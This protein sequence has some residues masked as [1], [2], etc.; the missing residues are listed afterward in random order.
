VAKYEI[1][2]IG[3]GKF[4]YFLG[5][6]LTD[7]GHTVV[8]IDSDPEKIKRAQDVL[9]QVY[10]ADATDKAD[11]YLHRFNCTYPR[12]LLQ[13]GL[14]GEYDFLDG[15]CFMN[16]CEQL[17]RTYDI[18]HRKIGTK[19]V[20]MI[21]IPHAIS[22]RRFGWYIDDIKKDIRFEPKVSLE[23]GLKHFV[24]WYK[25]FYEII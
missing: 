11:I 8:G 19:F 23:E 21:T 24:S 3:L 16:G 7:L 14:N 6:S 4:G 20:D 9:T 17:R 15:F 5:Q 1:G 13:L 12:C 10:Q 18:W 25:D 22:E 2:I